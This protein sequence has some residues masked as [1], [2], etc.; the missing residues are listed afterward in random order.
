MLPSAE[1]DAPLPVNR[2][3]H[4]QRWLVQ[5]HDYPKERCLFLHH[6][7][8]SIDVPAPWPSGDDLNHKRLSFASA[9]AEPPHQVRPQA[10][11]ACSCPFYLATKTL[12]Y[13]VLER[14]MKGT[15]KLDGRERSPGSGHNS[16][17]ADRS[18]SIEHIETRPS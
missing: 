3:A 10:A 1:I 2:I 7:R 15:P 6:P 4:S 9:V 12:G 8:K 16:A 18:S 14:S 5:R 13:P 17:A 11:I